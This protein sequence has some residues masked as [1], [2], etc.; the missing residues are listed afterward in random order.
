[1]GV[2]LTW[3]IFEAAGWSAQLKLSGCGLRN[4]CKWT[5]M[6]SEKYQCFSSWEKGIDFLFTFCYLEGFGTE[7]L[8]YKNEYKKSSWK[9]AVL[10]ISFLRILECSSRCEHFYSFQLIYQ[11]IFQHVQTN[12]NQTSHCLIWFLF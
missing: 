7:L 9:K 1:M 12:W 2:I 8:L 4:S 6:Y 3:G 10:N 11:V 5:N